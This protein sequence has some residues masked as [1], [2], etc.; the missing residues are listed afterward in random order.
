MFKDSKIYVAGHTG[1]LG[2][3]LI[4]KL[5]EQGYSRVVTRSHAE[6]DLTDK[7]A[8]FDFFSIENPEY[9]FL[10]AGKVGGIVSN[11][12]YPA[13]YLHINLAI[14]D[15]VFE[16]SQKYE[17]R[18]LLFYG[19][20]CIYPKFSPQPI[21]EQYLLT[22][23][24]EETSEGYATA[25][26]AGIIAC[27]VYN[28]QSRSRSTSGQT[29]RFIALVPSNMYGPNDNFNLESCHVLS[30]LIRR[31]HESK[32][33]HT[34]S[35]T[36]WGS[37]TPR[38]EFIFSE[39]VAEASLFAMEHI[40][41]L[42]NRHYNVG[43]GVDYS[44]KELTASVAEIVGY[45]GKVLWD[46]S[47]PDG[48]PRKL[49]DSSRFLSLGWR[50]TVSI[51][52]GIRKTYQWYQR[53]EQKSEVRKPRCTSGSSVL[54]PSKIQAVILAGGL[55]ARLKSVV[56]DKPKVLAEVLNRPFLAYLL[57]Q[58]SS[59]GIREVVLCTGYMAGQVKERFGQFYGHLYILYSTEKQPLGTGGALRL[60]LP[61]LWSETVLIM[62]GDSYTDLDLGVYVDWFF[63]KNGDVALILT[64]VPNTARYGRV[65]INQDE[66]I[67]AF[68]EKGTSSDAG[69][70]NAGIYLMKKSLLASIPA[71]RPYSLE[72]EF[73][74]ALTG[75][76]LLGY[77]AKGRFIDI[78]T[79]ASYVA[80]EEFF[81]VKSL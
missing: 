26:I 62:N 44:I 50:P 23:P 47:K 11:K 51:D 38:R 53:R 70:I 20:S 3:A 81:A 59:A 76:K 61:R 21:K 28:Q 35:V 34:E 80:A 1:L 32:I 6:L 36:L 16:A 58:V 24:L 13:D 30:A 64:K 67:T 60:A 52:E 68:D 54:C 22:A 57:D 9:V 31:F 63:R 46:T 37:G 74:P 33:N 66:C 40:E 78:G 72:R 25:K 45:E 18:R 5:S 56:S 73:F 14:Q 10:A 17:I 29:N 15:N 41:Q 27:R 55:G 12:T 43:T 4:R 79:P 65:T 75:K 7:R 19:S 71:D 39:D 69:W 42:E 8:V 77:R 49:L 2:S 48:A